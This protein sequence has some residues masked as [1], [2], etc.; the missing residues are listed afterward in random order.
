MLIKISGYL[1]EVH[2]QDKS[3]ERTDLRTS[4]VPSC[5]IGPIPASNFFVAVSVIFLLSFS[6]SL[7]HSVLI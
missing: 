4:G 6:L 1:I 5:A 2:I 3:K 7:E